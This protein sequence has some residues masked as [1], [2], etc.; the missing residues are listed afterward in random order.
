MNERSLSARS[1]GT[2]ESPWRAAGY[3]LLLLAALH[4]AVGP[5]VQLGEWSVRS[6]T[7]S[8]IAEAMAWRQGRLDIGERT[9]DTAFKD[10]RAY[11]VFPPLFSMLGYVSA[12][13]QAWQNYPV[14]PLYRPWH[15]AMVALPVPLVG[16]WALRRV[17][18]DSARSALLTFAWIAGTPLL[19]CAESAG[20]GGM[21]STNHVLSQTGL[22]LMLGARGPAFNMFAAG[23]GVLIAGFTRPQT[24]ILTLPLL[25]DA[26]MIGE[27]KRTLRLSVILVATVIVIGVT[28]TLNALK[29]GSPFDTGYALIYQGRT[30][31][32][33]QRAAV[34]LFSIEHVP[35]N[36]WFMNVAFPA[37]RI[38]AGGLRL[39]PDSNGASIWWTMPWLGYVLIDARQWWSDRSRRYWTLASFALMGLL[40]CYHS[41]GYAQPGFYRFALDFIPV[42]LVVIAPWM[43]QGKRTP[44]TI[45]ALTWSCLYFNLLP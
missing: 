40:L 20:T 10:G 4:L 5:R 1:G 2:G 12:T 25:H 38:D 43:W 27:A 11:N 22:M 41:T 15:V 26:W 8:N 37:I 6:E 28:M 33:A 24:L 45:A 9:H 32:L 19:P 31:E 30:D 3:L 18:G 42:W 34:G 16:F 21:S 14:D 7:N 29:F 44:W 35:K 39:L 23:A 17:T 13:L 36:A